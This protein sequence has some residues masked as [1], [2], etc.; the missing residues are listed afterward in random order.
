MSQPNSG[1][2]FSIDGP[3]GH[4]PIQHD[5]QPSSRQNGRASAD[6]LADTAKADLSNGFEGRPIQPRPQQQVVN[7]TQRIQEQQPIIKNQLQQNQPSNQQQSQQ[8]QQTQ[9]QQQPQQPQPQHQ[10]LEQPER[11]PSVPVLLT[12]QPYHDNIVIDRV[13]FVPQGQPIPVHTAQF[14]PE[15]VIAAPDSLQYSQIHSG[16]YNPSQG[17]YVSRDA[18]FRDSGLYSQLATASGSY[19]QQ[20]Q[21]SPLPSQLAGGQP[22]TYY[23]NKSLGPPPPPVAAGYVHFAPQI[24][25]SQYPQTVMNA[26][27]YNA[28]KSMYPPPQYTQQPPQQQQQPSSAQHSP[29]PQRFSQE[30]SQYQSQP[31]IQPIA[32]NVSHTVAAPQQGLSERSSRGPKPIVP[33]R[34]NS[35]ITYDTGHRKSASVDVPTT[36]K[37]KEG[38]ENIAGEG[39]MTQDGGQDNQ[40]RRYAVST[41]QNSRTRQDGLY[42]KTNGES[43]REQALGSADDAE[44]AG[45][46]DCGIYV[47]RSEHRKSVSVDV[48]SSFPKRNDTI[49]FTFPGDGNAQQ[50]TGPLPTRKPIATVNIM[51]SKPVETTLPPDFSMEQRRL[52]VNT[53]MRMSPMPVLPPVSAVPKGILV[54]GERKSVEWSSLSPNQRIMIPQENRRSDYFEDHR[55]S[56]M[57]VSVDGK[58]FE[59][60]RRSPMTFVPIRDTNASDRINQKSPNNLANQNFEKTRAELAIWA[61]QRQRQEIESRIMENRGMFT[62]SP[63]S[64]GQSEERRPESSRSYVQLDKETRMSVPPSAFQPIISQNSIMEQ[65]RH[66][67]HVS[68]DLTKH[69]ELTRKEFDDA[70]LTGSVI[71]LGPT[72]TTTT[73]PVMSQRAS[74]NIC[75]QYPALSEAKLDTKMTLNIATDFNETP[76]KP[77][78]QVDHII[79]SHRKSQHVSAN[80][81]SAAKNH[82]NNQNQTDQSGEKPDT[83]QMPN[84][85]LLHNQ[86]SIDFISEKLSQCERQQCDLQAKLQSLQSQN[87]ILDRVAQFQYQHS[88][89]Q[90]RMHSLQLQSQIAEK[91]SQKQSSEFS[92]TSSRP[93]S[94]E[95]EQTNKSILNQCINASRQLYQQSHLSTVNPQ[96]QVSASYFATTDRVSPRLQFQQP[97]DDSDHESIQIPSISQMPLPNLAQFDRADILPPSSSCSSSRNSYVQRGGSGMPNDD[98]P[99]AVAASVN[100]TGTLKKVPPEKPP[101]T[102]LIVQSPDTEVNLMQIAMRAL[103]VLSH[104]FLPVRVYARK[105]FHP[106]FSLRLQRCVI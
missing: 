62:T 29:N 69:M 57:T 31:I 105:L 1:S 34:V 21:Q 83:H 48:T 3:N 26:G 84:H 80:L 51:D 5:E 60:I 103:C 81:I 37:P 16:M 17:Q 14:A 96:L 97:P 19:V 36:P 76:P 100:F 73:A 9:Q 49:T 61:E 54:T 53:A 89:L 30:L 8:Y 32:Q 102:S 12:H 15:Y 91:L 71:N 56:P 94:N 44:N 24:H 75:Y 82:E 70:H 101:R 86:H 7:E 65:R 11:P 47:S 66:L 39:Q 45:N 2:G 58:R 22:T 85:Q 64:R 63:R 88:D 72:S 25:Y 59:E 98:G 27:P 18:A 68:A 4:T 95:Q 38:C 20:S 28:Q 35:K 40:D 78:D 23:A 67:R 93:T 50:D 42:V 87:E 55:R 10:H 99:C 77:L 90:A 13:Q 33:P 6:I 46:A 41:N 92:Q 52:D 79:H 106:C 104:G 74:P 43:S